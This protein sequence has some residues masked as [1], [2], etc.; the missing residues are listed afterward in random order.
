[1]PM[2]VF[3]EAFGPTRVTGSF[4]SGTPGEI[5]LARAARPDAEAL[6]FDADGMAPLTLP[7]GP[8]QAE[9]ARLHDCVQA[10]HAKWSEAASAGAHP[11]TEPELL[12][13]R[14]T[15][16]EMKYPYV[17]AVNRVSGV[18]QMR[19]TV[20]ATGR[21][22]EC[23]VQ[24]STWNADFGKAACDSYKHYATFRPAK[25]AAGKAVPAL[26]RTSSAFI[27]LNM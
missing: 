27:V 21:V 7:I 1:M 6:H 16:W 26:Y 2:I 14:D 13:N 12:P 3:L 8:M 10:L 23:V 18:V 19:M 17:L 25:D 15:G 22:R 24:R 11:V 20:D 5:A 9:Y 4:W